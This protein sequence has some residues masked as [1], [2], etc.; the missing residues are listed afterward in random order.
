MHDHPQFS[1]WILIALAKVYF[2][3]IFITAKKYVCIS[4]HRP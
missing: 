2:S 4:T 3:H 1:I